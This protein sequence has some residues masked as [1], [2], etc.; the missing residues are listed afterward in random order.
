MSTA[1]VNITAPIVTGNAAQPALL[2]CT[3]GVWSSDA[4]SFVYQWASG[5]V[6]IDGADSGYYETT[7][8]DVGNLVTCTVTAA[9]SYGSTSATSNAIGPVT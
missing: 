9:N 3:Q 6:N 1:P 4:I 7:A 2:T 8:S 5:G